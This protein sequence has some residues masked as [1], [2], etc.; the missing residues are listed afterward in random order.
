[1]RRVGMAGDSAGFDG[2]VERVRG[3]FPVDPDD[4]RHGW[5]VLISVAVAA[6]LLWCGLL[7]LWATPAP[8]GFEVG[9]MQEGP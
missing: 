2:G 1:M 4:R 7:L 6:V 9:L 8:P 3:K 5:L